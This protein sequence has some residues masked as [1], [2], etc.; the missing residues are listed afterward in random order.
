M[1][2]IRL[3]LL[4]LC[5]AVIAG[6]ATAQP[7]S[8]LGAGSGPDH[9]GVVPSELVTLCHIPPGSPT[10]TTT[11]HVRATGVWS[12]LAHGDLEG[13]CADDCGKDQ[14]PVQKTGQTACWDVN[15]ELVP[16]SGTGQDGENQAGVAITPRFMENLDGTVT[17]GLTGLVW[18][19]DATCFAES[20]WLAALAG[21]AALADGACGLSDGSIP[22]DWR[23]PNAREA[24]SMI[25]FG[26][27]NPAL[28]ADHPFVVPV[29][30]GLT[31]FYYWSSTSLVQFPYNA[32]IV[33]LNDGILTTGAKSSNTLLVWPVRSTP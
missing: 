26:Q 25:D 10:S 20:N 22:G 30:S 7:A 18:L 14:A 17:D 23:L 32:F 27:W 9:A 28:A 16:C 12:H 5:S 21:A 19:Q 11:I 3:V 2:N 15:G 33:R 13:A 8:P 31:P 6:P 4:L 24:M 1:R 29:F